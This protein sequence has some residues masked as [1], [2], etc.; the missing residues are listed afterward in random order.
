MSTTPTES[1][2]TG[3]N[4]QTMT[5]ADD[6]L[7]RRKY[8]G[9]SVLRTEDPVFLTG[10]GKYTD[11]VHLPGMLHA[12]FLRSPY[13]HAKI[14]SIDKTRALALDG[15]HAVYTEADFE[16]I[17]G[18]YVTTVHREEVLTVDR[19]IMDSTV[20]RYV[21]QP[22]AVVLA[23]SRYLAEDGVDLIDIKWEPLE[24]VMDAEKALEPDSTLVREDLGTNNFAHIEFQRGDTEGLFEGAAHVFSK[25]FHHGRFMAAPLEPRGVIADWDVASDELVVWSST[26]IPHLIRTFTA[27]PLGIAESKMRVIADHVGGGFGMKAH[28]FDEE[29]LIP[30]SS[31]LSG[32]PIKWIEDRYENLAASLHSKEMIIYLEAAVDKDGKFL[33]FKGHYI[34]VGGAWPAHP[35]TSLIDT[36]PAASLLPSI[37]DIQAVSTQIDAPLTNRCP[38]GAYR[39]VGWTPGHVARETFIDDIA[40]EMEIDPAEI[41]L[42]NSIPDEPFVS[43]TGMK[44]DG[45]SYSASLRKTLE[46]I[47]YEGLRKKQAE[48]LKEGRYLGIG[49]SPYVE[50][51]AW[52]SEVAKANGFAAE[53]FDAANV[54]VEPD[55][56]ITV[57]TGCHN[58]GQAHYTTLAQVAA[59]TLG[60]SFESIRVIEN[61]SSQAVYGTGTYASRTAVVAG[62]AIM[63]AGKEVREKIIRLAAHAMEVSPEDVD[64]AD[65]IASVKG[66]PDKSMT[67]AELGFMSYYGGSSRV[68]GVEPALTST[69]SYDPPETYSNG[70]IIA[71]VEVDVE[72]GFVDLQHIACCEDCGTMLNPMV[73]DGQMVGAISHGIGGAMYEDLAYADN[74]Q[75][76]SASLMDYLYPST[77]EVPHMEISHIE[78]PSVVTEGGIK[79]MGESGNIAAGAACINAIADA[80]SSFGKIEINKTPIG[81]SDVMDLIR[82]LRGAK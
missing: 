17:L 54:T 1:L 2:N 50:P 26:Q 66:V 45:G 33:A 31:K 28:V 29:A 56:S 72:T 58:H 52:G 70:T 44:Y 16:P 60:V 14:L 38:T 9:M 78:T 4:I 46:M 3:L 64:L 81:P 43:V 76:L 15:V 5:E 35:W 8:I 80:L 68:P 21:G 71:I 73:V 13:P 69:R 53:F 7:G 18:H 10:R 63:R 65:G 36:L 40:R 24:P 82:G 55:G 11:D 49:I 59:D 62:G 74:G 77:T 67:M 34:G 25:R 22:I 79:G 48:L 30:A 27:G 47:D 41:R 51:T 42:M 20:A 32:K 61:D 23:D 37:Y 19:P 6:V 39:G 12:A 57:T 75:F